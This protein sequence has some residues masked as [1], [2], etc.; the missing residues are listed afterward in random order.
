MKAITA[1]SHP[2]TYDLRIVLNID[3]VEQALQTFGDYFPGD[4]I[5]SIQPEVAAV[6][7]GV[8]VLPSE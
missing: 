5:N 1:P 4:S 2:G 7:V 8:V 3:E 6:A